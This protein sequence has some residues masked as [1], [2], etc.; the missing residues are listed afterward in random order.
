MTDN[1]NVAVAFIAGVV[2]FIS[3]CILPVVPSYLS[4]IGGVSSIEFKDGRVAKWGIFIKTLYFVSG[5]SLVFILLGVIFSGT[6]AILS[7]FSR[8][9]NIIAGTVV[10]VL[11][12]NFIFDFWKALNIEKRFHFNQKP[13]GF[14]GAALLGMAF[15]AGWTPCIGPILASILFLA[16]TSSSV[17]HGTS[18]LAVYSLGLGTP[19]IMAG[20]FF[21]FFMRQ[22]NK[23]KP[24][25]PMIRIISGIFLFALGVLIFIG[26]LTRVNA[27]LFSLAGR[28]NGWV[29]RE[30]FA[31]SRLFAI[32]FFAISL[33]LTFFY[34]RRVVRIVKHSPFSLWNIL[35]PGRIAVIILFTILAVLSITN[36]VGFTETL[37]RWLTFQGI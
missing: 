11:G 18:L 26:S 21:S 13:A 20:L 6:G 14:T 32:V 5:F 31:M 23:I 2:S 37:T 15:G 33:L 34:V 28:L 9:V 19:F 35:F 10:M 29:E 3:P 22:I 36:I 30:P 24:Y 4:F 27:F 7:D 25:L 8:I 16:G 1:L 12:L 17:V